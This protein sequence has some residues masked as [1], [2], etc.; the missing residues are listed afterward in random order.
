LSD[1]SSFYKNTILNFHHKTLAA[2][3]LKP[4]AYLEFFS[5]FGSLLASHNVDQCFSN[6]GPL[7]C[8]GRFEKKIQKLY[9]TL[10]ELKIRPYVS[11]L[12]CLCWL[13]FKEKVGE[14]FMSIT[15]CL[16]NIIYKN[17]SN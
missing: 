1:F 12:N 4:E 17:T 9:K 6:C 3:L 13:N 5:H 11:V 8:A 2:V 7:L 15:S 16:S 10:N 14:L